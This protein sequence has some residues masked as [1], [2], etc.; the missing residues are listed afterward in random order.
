M[1]GSIL[2]FLWTNA[3]IKILVGILV[4]GSIVYYDTQPD[5]TVACSRVSY[6]PNRS[7]VYN[8]MAGFSAASLKNPYKIPVYTTITSS[9]RS[10]AWLTSIGDVETAKKIR[11]SLGAPVVIGPGA[12]MAVGSGEG[13]VYIQSSQRF[14]LS[15]VWD[16]PNA[17]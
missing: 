8:C 1:E 6:V 16:V 2:G 17:N 11:K 7:I 10:E 5:S 3:T 14:L 4:V 9:V 15:V 13:L 12:F